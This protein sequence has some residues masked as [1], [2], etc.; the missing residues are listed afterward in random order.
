MGEERP[1]IVVIGVGNELRGDDAAGVIVARR[2]ATMSLPDNVEVIEGHTGGLN[3]LFDMEGA[4][5]AIVV[6][7]V[8]MG[9]EP[10]HV[11][12][13]EADEVDVKVAQRIASLHHVSLADV[14]E[15]AKLTGC[16]ARITLVGI[17]PQTVLPGR[18]LSE[19]VLGCVDRVVELVA[20]LVQSTANMDAASVRERDTGQSGACG[21][22]ANDGRL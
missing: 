3:L 8:D 9:A 16:S 14:L 18:E 19:A 2:L 17:Q 7:A 1:R 5:W 13:M 10:G 22:N 21:D 6:D 4:E 12:V 15:L 20:S 11:E